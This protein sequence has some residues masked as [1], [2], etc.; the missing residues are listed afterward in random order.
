MLRDFKK[1]MGISTDQAQEN[2]QRMAEAISG[3]TAVSQKD[4]NMLDS[5]RQYWEHQLKLLRGYEKNPAKLDENVRIIEGWID[6][7]VRFLGD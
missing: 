7:I 4:R 1:S 5:L 3:G 6:D 2:L